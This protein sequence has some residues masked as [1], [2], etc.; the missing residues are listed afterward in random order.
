MDCNL[1]VRLLCPWDLQA[2]ILEWVAMS[3]SRGSSQPRDQTSV[4]HISCLGR[5][6]FFTT[7]ATREGHAEFTCWLGVFLCV[8]TGDF[9]VY[10]ST[11]STK[12]IDR[13]GSLFCVTAILESWF[14]LHSLGQGNRNQRKPFFASQAPIRRNVATPQSPCRAGAL[15]R[16]CLDAWR[17]KG[18]DSDQPSQMPQLHR[19]ECCSWSSRHSS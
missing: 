3:S 15:P 4:S 13:R 8:V 11:P 5:Q 18:V 19:R 9:S 14:S 12:K 6:V 16:S 10:R 1:P 17:Q 2:R 7:S